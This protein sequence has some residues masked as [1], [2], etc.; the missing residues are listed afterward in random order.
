MVGGAES[1]EPAPDTPNR[2]A[3]QVRC[4]ELIDCAE[5]EAV[6]T[7]VVTP[8][9]RSADPYFIMLDIMGGQSLSGSEQAP[10]S[11]R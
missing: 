6:P 8:K 4:S 7:R 9:A 2:L 10:K 5:A 3:Y 11:Q 1:T